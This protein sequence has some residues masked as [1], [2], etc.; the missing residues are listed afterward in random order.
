MT[1]RAAIMKRTGI[2]AA[3][4]MLSV[5]TT[6]AGTSFRL[7]VGLPVAAG[8]DF[9]LKGSV[10]VVRAVVCDDVAAARLSATAEGM[11]NGQRQSLPVRLTGT[12]TPGVYAIQQ[13]W[14]MQ[15]TWILHLAGTCPSPKAAASTIVPMQKTGF[16]RE[17]TQVLR[18][19][20]TSAQ[21]E[22]ALAELVRTQS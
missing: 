20:A 12:R 8:A 3:A 9:K 10:L 1:G 22:A 17:K 14:P 15:G 21:V 4:V 19:P 13:Q 11:V 5:I 6:W 7:E 16:I 18:E 2:I